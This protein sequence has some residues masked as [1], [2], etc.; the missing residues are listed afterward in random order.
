[1]KITRRQY[2]RRR[3]CNDNTYIWHSY[4]YRATI[5][6]LYRFGESARHNVNNSPISVTFTCGYY[7]NR[8]VNCA[9]RQRPVSGRCPRAKKFSWN[10]GRILRIVSSS[11]RRLSRLHRRLEPVL[12]QRTIISAQR[13]RPG[14][15]RS[16]GQHA[17]APGGV[18]LADA[19]FAVLLQRKAVLI[20]GLGHDLAGRRVSGDGYRS[21]G[22]SRASQVHSLAPRAIWFLEAQCRPLPFMFRRQAWCPISS[23]R[24]SVARISFG[25]GVASCTF[26]PLRPLRAFRPLDSWVTLGASRA[27]RA[28][29]AFLASRASRA[30]IASVAFRPLNSLRA[31]RAGVS[32]VALCAVST[33]RPLDAL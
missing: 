2:N 7:K 3:F 8:S 20:A 12:S 6:T 33:G 22:A 27:L 18:G 21:G 17:A 23:G 4:L 28:S 16:A 11:L 24:A 25:A 26:L 13:H 1:M 32:R 29:I 15:R 5:S 10:I 31:L 9:S 19:Q 14:L 30:G